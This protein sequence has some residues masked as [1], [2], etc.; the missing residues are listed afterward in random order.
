MIR[1]AFNLWLATTESRV[2]RCRYLSR[3]AMGNQ[4]RRWSSPEPSPP[5][6]TDDSYMK[7]HDLGRSFSFLGRSDMSGAP[8]LPRRA[9]VLRIYIGQAHHS[10]ASLVRADP[11][12]IA[13]RRR[14]RR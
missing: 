11:T 2:L 8:P 14:S 13:G 10:E 1:T 6:G 9:K 3:S 12:E 7:V 4:R 5:W